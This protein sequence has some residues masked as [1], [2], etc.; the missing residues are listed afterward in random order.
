MARIGFVVVAARRG[1]APPIELAAVVGQREPFDLGAAEIDADPHRIT[2]C[3]RCRADR[4]SPRPAPDAD[5]SAPGRARPTTACRRF[6]NR[7]ASSAADAARASRADVSAAPAG[8]ARNR[9]RQAG[10][11]HQQRHL[12]GGHA[13]FDRHVRAERDGQRLR[14]FLFLPAASSSSATFS[15]GCSRADTPNR[16]LPRQ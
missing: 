12:A 6:P 5:P 11:L 2:E 14:R 13:C 10:L 9:L 4:R 7:G 15:I 16:Q 1:D 8:P 3:A